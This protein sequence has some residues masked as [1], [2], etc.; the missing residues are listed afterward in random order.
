MTNPEL[1]LKL[2]EIQAVKFGSFTLKSGIISPIYIDLRLIVSYPGLLQ[3]VGEA[4]WKKIESIPL[5]HLCGVPYTALPIATAISLKHQKPMLMRRKE[6]KGHGTKKE[7]EGVFRP[8][9]HCVV[10]EDLITSG[11]SILETVEPLKAE[12]LKVSHAAVLID[13]EQGGCRHLEDKGISVHSVMTISTLL[14]T[15]YEKGKI[16]QNTLNRTLEFIRTTPS[17][18][19]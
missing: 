6:A 12:G 10:I 19:S 4:I 7:I 15:L 16:D 5:D 17:N 2:Q 3:D 1:I 11:A 8:G 18:P 9:E 14:R 13:R